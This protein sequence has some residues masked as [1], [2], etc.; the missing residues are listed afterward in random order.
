[1][2]QDRR[3]NWIKTGIEYTDGLMHFSVVVTR[4]ASRTGR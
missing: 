3:R 1:M 4:A 2:L